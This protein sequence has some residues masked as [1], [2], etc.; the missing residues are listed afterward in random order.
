MKFKVGEDLDDD[1]LSPH[2]VQDVESSAGTAT[3]Y[4]DTIPH[5][6][7][8]RPSTGFGFK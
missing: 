7:E 8:F 2:T 5:A 4:G 6:I 3:L 1:I